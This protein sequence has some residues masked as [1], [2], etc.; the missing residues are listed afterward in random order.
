[1]E[2]LHGRS[3]EDW[4]R[5]APKI[6]GPAVVRLGRQIADG[7][8]V[9]HGS[10]LIHR[11]LKPANIWLEAPKARVKILDFG[12]A[13]FTEDDSHL[14]Q[15]GMIVGTPS[16][17]S[18]EQ[19]RGE[20]LDARSDLFSLGCVLYELC[21]G[22][23]PFQAPTTMAVLT[24]LA[25]S[26]PKPVREVRPTVPEELS[27]L[28]M[29][30]LAKDPAERPASAE[31][32]VARLQKIEGRLNARPAARAP[33]QLLAQAPASCPATHR[34]RPARAKAPTR[35][36]KAKARTARRRRANTLLAVGLPAAALVAVLV[37]GLTFLFSSGPGRSP[38]AVPPAKAFLSD[39]TLVNDNNPNKAPP[40]PPGEPAPPSLPE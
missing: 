35:S 24:A 14:T 12:L 25:V 40:A 39:L 11:D 13:R 21:C 34:E 10:G 7:L 28:V 4:T 1:M 38:A 15:T 29:Q 17:M 18:P 37:I 2:L 22:A 8:A 9:I 31:A 32:V 33:S 27:D 6:G 16:Y 23:R 5:Q 36:R 19:A 26:N 30:L 3:L 20:M